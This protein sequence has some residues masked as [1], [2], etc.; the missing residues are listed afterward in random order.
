MPV[1]TLLGATGSTGSA[2]IRSLLSQ[3]PENLE[4]KVFVRSA[5]KLRKAFPDLEN[6]LAFRT[7]II[8]G[9]PSTHSATQECLA[10]ADVIMACIGSNV[11][12]PGMSIIHDTATAV[13]SALKTQRHTQGPAYKTPTVIQL[14]TASLNPT[15]KAALPWIAQL[16]VSFCFYHVYADLDRACKLYESSA[17]ESPGLLQYI[18][19]DPPAIHDPDGT[20]PTG[21]KLILE[22]KQEPALS[23]ADLGAAF[24]EVAER[25]GEFAGNAVGVTATGQVT[26]TVG[27]LVGYMAE[28]AKGRIWG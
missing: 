1:Y 26:Q 9:V 25:R 4:L 12:T 11:S 8:E 16:L 21:Y 15:Y 22:E 18:F 17:A 13:I 19:V 23:Y 24:C 6:T 2:I 20:V 3:P 14:R 27:K 28:G 7:T 5:P 10:N